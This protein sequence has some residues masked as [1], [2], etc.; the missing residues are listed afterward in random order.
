MTFLVLLLMAMGKKINLSDRLILRE[1]LNHDDFGE[2]ITLIKRIFKYTLV[3]ESIGAIFLSTVFIPNFG[4]Q[5]GI[6]YSIFHSISAFCNAGIDILG[7]NSFMNYSNN[8]VVNIT[9][10]LLIIIG[11]LGFTVW[12]DITGVIKKH[13]RDKIAIKKLIKELTLHTKIVL[14]TTIILLIT[15]TFFIFIFEFNNVTTM[16]HNTLPEKILKSAFQSTTLRTAGFYTINQNE[17]T[18]VTKLI[19]M[20]YMFVGGSP[21]STAGGIKNVT[22]F[23]VILLII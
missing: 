5:K 22:I 3:L 21:G 4:L 1:A 8:I 23:V 19:S 11:G 2:V 10:M 15:G 14:T 7:N 16:A 13:L 20:C 17:M 9:I 18:T 6:F 12:N